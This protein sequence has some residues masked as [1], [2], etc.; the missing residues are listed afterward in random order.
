MSD[1]VWSDPVCIYERVSARKCSGCGAVGFFVDDISPNEDLEA[2]N[3]P[4]PKDCAGTKSMV[5]AGHFAWNFENPPSWLG[6]EHDKWT[7]GEED[8]S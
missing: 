2:Q 8:R 3:P 4:M 1:H 7:W 5:E 6:G